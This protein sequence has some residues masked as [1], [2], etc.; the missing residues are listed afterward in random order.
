MMLTLEKKQ[1]KVAMAK[2]HAEADRLVAGFFTH[3]EDNKG[4]SVGCDAFDIRAIKG[5]DWSL[6]DGPGDY[7]AYVADYFGTPEWLEHLR[8]AVF[9]GLP[10]EDR[11]DWHVN[12]AEALPV[13]VSFGPIKHRILRDILLEVSAPS[14][15]DGDEDW[16]VAC[17]T[18]VQSVAA[19]HEQAITKTVQNEDWAA[20]RDAARAVAWDAASAA[21]WDAA[22]DAARDAARAVAWDAASAAARD[23]AASVAW[24]AASAAAR[25][26]AASVAYKQIAEITLK[27]LREAA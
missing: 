15:G 17:R 25:D 24:A 1:E 18:A 26:A 2:A 20:A 27:H 5:E 9:E 13:G 6:W 14:I 8:D 10:K 21:A 12:I 22:W 7:H 11:S 19:L 3:E 23:A 4:C 16:R